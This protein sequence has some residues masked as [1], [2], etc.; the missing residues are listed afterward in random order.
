MSAITE[1]NSRKVSEFY[2]NVFS[3]MQ[4]IMYITAAG[5]LLVLRPIIMPFFGSKEFEMAYMYVPFLVL[6]VVFQ[7][8]NNFLSSIYEAK[9]KT[10]HSLVTSIIGAATNIGLNLV[11]LN[12]PLGVI[13]AAVATLACYLLVYIIRAI[14]TRQ[15]LTVNVD[16]LKMAINIMLISTMSVCIMTLDQGLLLNVLN[17]ILFIILCAI[18]FKTAAQAVKLFIRRR[19]GR[20]G[21]PEDGAEKAD[22]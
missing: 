3:M 16:Y 9:N 14:D 6:A 17:C 4:T 22:K 12:S 7:S 21:N 8:F 19:T 2:S 1:R 20:G 13:G 11:L 15:F 10:S 5:I 18:N